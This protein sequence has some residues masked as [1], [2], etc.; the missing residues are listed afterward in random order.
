MSVRW[1]KE[2][3]IAAILDLKKADVPLN[4]RSVRDS[5]RSLW[6][7]AVRY[8]GSWGSA[9]EA[10]GLSHQA[11]RHKSGRR[12]NKW[13][14]EA[15]ISDM[16]RLHAEGV[17]L[18]SVVKSN[19][20]HSLVYAARAYYGSWRKA[21]LAA[22][23]DVTPPRRRAA[24]VWSKEIIIATIRAHYEA[25]QPLHSY[26]VETEMPRLYAAA[27]KYF[28]GWAQA[29]AAAGLDYSQPRRVKRW[30][31]DEILARVS[32][33]EKEGVRLNAGT[34]YRNYVSLWAAAVE[35]FG[36]WSLALKAAG[37]DYKRHY[38]RW[39]TKSWIATMDEAIYEGILKKD[40]RGVKKK[41]TT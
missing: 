16:R 12:E 28:G 10:S 14:K 13:N 7:A 41:K 22:G 37:I 18:R 11:I 21:Y 8:F 15:V 40:I 39:S 19:Q 36:S 6:A 24:W 25:A 26:F 20:Y 34:I 33:L 23:V 32:E 27:V 4:A 3:I 29:I 9:I 38:K 17:N 35:Y 5:H 1:N 2:V 31:A 30:S